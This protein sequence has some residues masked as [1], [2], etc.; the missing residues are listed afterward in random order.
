MK[1]VT[2]SCIREV[3]YSGLRLGL[4]EP[5]KHAMGATDRHNTPLYIKFAAGAVTG[6]LGSALTTPFDLVKVRYV[7]ARDYMPGCST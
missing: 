2:A 7:M 3:F 4:Y 1:G 6:A 5:T